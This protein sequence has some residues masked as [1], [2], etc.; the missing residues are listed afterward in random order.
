MVA[1]RTGC[2]LLPRTNRPRCPGPPLGIRRG[3]SHRLPPSAPDGSP[4]PNCDAPNPSPRRS[5]RPA[6]P[7]SSGRGTALLE[8]TGPAQSLRQDRESPSNVSG[9]LRAGTNAL[10]V[11][12]PPTPRT[13]RAARGAGVNRGNRKRIIRLLSVSCRAG[14]RLSMSANI[15]ASQRG[16]KLARRGESGHEVE[17]CK[18]R[19]YGR[20]A[21]LAGCAGIK[22]IARGV[23]QEWR[24]VRRLAEYGFGLQ[25]ACR[26][27]FIGHLT[28]TI[29]IMFARH[30]DRC[31]PHPGVL[32]QTCFEFASTGR[33]RAKIERTGTELIASIIEDY[34]PDPRPQTPLLQRAVC[35]SARSATRLP[36][37]RGQ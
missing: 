14:L 26:P 2:R 5:A 12:P 30:Q 10:P 18:R 22:T 33:E 37:S 19:P 8:R 24:G 13:A 23:D 31:V 36:G 11:P 25:D 32:R 15:E 34:R 6:P 1:S 21:L 16:R 3:A 17:D 7:R 4:I 27:T 9:T 28:R 35:I 29:G 20:A